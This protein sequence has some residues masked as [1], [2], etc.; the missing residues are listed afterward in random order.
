[1]FSIA[2]VYRA[3]STPVSRWF[4]LTKNEVNSETLAACMRL[5]RHFSA[6]FFNVVFTL[7]ARRSAANSGIDENFVFRRQRFSL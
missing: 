1:M 4:V 5:A 2:T 6:R 7:P 3:M